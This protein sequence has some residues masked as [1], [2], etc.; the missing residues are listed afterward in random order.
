VDIFLVRHGEAAASWGKDPDPGLS[1]LGKTQARATADV[2]LARIDSPVEIIS[3]PL[4]RAQETAEPLAR[5]L[6]LQIAIDDAYREVPAPVPLA[7]RQT[8]LRQFMQQGWS[9]QPEE[10]C[11]WRDRILDQLRELTTPT[12]IFTHFLVLNAVVGHLLK[13]PE[14]LN[15]WPDNASVTQL[16][17]EG[18]TLVLEELGAQL[19]RGVVN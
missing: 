16:K 12:V 4:Q 3:S 2:L 9:E 5:A 13:R 8:W 7:Q 15:F 17:L 19:D 1:P 14:I 10:L 18:G 11:Q 6:G